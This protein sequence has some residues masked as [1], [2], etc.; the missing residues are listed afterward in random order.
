MLLFHGF[1]EEVL[2]KPIEAGADCLKIVTGYTAHAMASWHMEEIQERYSDK[3]TG[4]IQ[5][6]L[7]VGMCND[8]VSL[9]LHNGLKQLMRESSASESARLTAQY[10]YQGA[11]VHSKLYLWEKAGSPLCAYM[12]SANYSQTAFSNRRREIMTKCDPKEA[13]RYF[14]SIESDSIYCN[15]AEVS[16]YIRFLKDFPVFSSRRKSTGNLS[17]PA[18]QP[19][20]PSVTLSFLTNDGKVAKT[21]G[22]NWGQR[23]GR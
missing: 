23:T 6:V 12:G 5:I 17:E 22:I 11:P 18:L 20:L 10:I 7:L 19:A 13:Q 14:E 9:S 21:S 16:K 2:M 1:R 8:G 15:H 4:P 3:L